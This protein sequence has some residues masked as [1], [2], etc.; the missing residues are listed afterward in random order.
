[1][2]I[3]PKSSDRSVVFIICYSSVSSLKRSQSRRGNDRP[4]PRQ[5]GTPAPVALPWQK[6]SARPLGD[7]PAREGD[8]TLLRNP[9]LPQG[10]L[11]LLQLLPLSPLAIVYNR[12]FILYLL[13]FTLEDMIVSRGQQPNNSCPCAPG[14]HEEE[15]CCPKETGPA[16]GESPRGGDEGGRAGRE[17]NTELVLGSGLLC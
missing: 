12:V 1:M 7:Q 10:R 13:L 6:A 3:H 16:D 2:I 17:V 14:P 8:P 11:R 15:R 4:V 9:P 5:P